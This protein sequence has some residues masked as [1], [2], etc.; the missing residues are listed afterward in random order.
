MDLDLT[1]SSYEMT[2]QVQENDLEQFCESFSKKNSII[3]ENDPKQNSISAN[4]KQSF[5]CIWVT[6]PYDFEFFT[7]GLND[8][9]ESE[10]VFLLIGEMA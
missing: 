5:S 7:W 3:W 10:C 8:V 9:S 2:S 1:F 4:E 6:K